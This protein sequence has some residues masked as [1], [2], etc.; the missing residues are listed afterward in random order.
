MAVCSAT[1]R[2]GSPCTLPASGPG[3]TC[4][5][6]KSPEHAE[7]RRGMASRAAKSKRGR[8]A[9]E[10]A[11]L[12]AALEGLAADVRQGTVEPKVASVLNQIRNTQLR[13]IE[14]ARR[15]H[16]QEEIEERI[17]RLEEPRVEAAWRA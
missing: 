17:A 15:I 8:G 5:A 16:E 7:K 9:G 3:G 11:E 4:W 13:A 2:D 6:H 14:L 1:K 10:L 12:K